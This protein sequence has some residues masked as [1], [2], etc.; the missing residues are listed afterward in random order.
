MRLR[1]NAKIDLLRGVPLFAA[2]S[3]KELGLIAT[4]VDELAQPAGTVLTEEGARGREFFVL[5]DGTVTVTKAGKPLSPLGPGDFFGEIALITDVP[6]TATVVAKTP[7]RLLVM[8]APAFRRLVEETPSIQGKVLLAL[9]R[10][11]APGT[12]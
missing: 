3:T 8:T 6:R 1:R 2:C 5:I 7:V 4:A 12:L 10:R 9:A 11:V